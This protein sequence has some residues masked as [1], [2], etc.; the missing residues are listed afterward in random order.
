MKKKAL[1]CPF[2]A[3]TLMAGSLLAFAS[4]SPANAVSGTLSYDCNTALGPQVFTAVVDT[5]APETMEVGEGAPVN[6]TSTV[7]VPAAMAETLYAIGARSISGTAV[8]TSTVGGEEVTANLTVPSTPVA[9]T[10]ALDTVASGAGAPLAPTEAGDLT[11]EAGNFTTTISVFNEAGEEIVLDGLLPAE[12]SCALQADQ[13]AVVD[14][15]AVTAPAD[16]EDDAGN[17]DEGTGDEG[18]ED[19]GNEAGNDDGAELPIG[20]NSGL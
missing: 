16:D 4:T 9:A 11:I 5:D 1:A 3:A 2:A 6:V 10:G 12:V 15:V 19:T 13:D 18:T 20:S 17:E 8:V 14:T 7:T